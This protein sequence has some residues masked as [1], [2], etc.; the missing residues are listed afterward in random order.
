M[1]TRPVATCLA[2]GI[3]FIHVFCLTE[4][5][6][7]EAGPASHPAATQP[8]TR[9]A[10]GELVSRLSSPEWRERRAAREAL[11]ALGPEAEGELR[12]IADA[13][14]LD[15]EA[16]ANVERLLKDFQE[17]R[18]VGATRVSLQRPRRAR[19]AGDRERP[20]PGEA[21]AVAAM[22]TFGQGPDDV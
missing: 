8:A 17:K 11:A 19:G 9:P 16:R 18:R 22:T 21:R 20:G 14:K 2:L 5:V 4:R 7:A 1:T 13:G 15:E 3:V 6:R 10:V 12:T